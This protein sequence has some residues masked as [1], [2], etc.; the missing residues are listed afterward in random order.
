MHIMFPLD[1]HAVKEYGIAKWQRDF[2]WPVSDNEFISMTNAIEAVIAKHINED[3]PELSD[4]LLIKRNLVSEYGH[5]LHAFWV[6]QRIP[7][8]GL[9]PLYTEKTLWYPQLAEGRLESHRGSLSHKR[10]STFPEIVVANQ[11]RGFVGKAGQTLRI[12]VRPGKLLDYLH[13]GTRGKVYGMPDHLVRCYLQ[14][15]VGWYSLTSAREWTVPLCDLSASYILKLQEYARH[16][17]DEISA[18]AR[19][20][21]IA[22]TSS[23]IAY[24]ISFT[25]DQILD[26]ARALFSLHQFFSPHP[27]NHVVVPVLGAPLQRAVALTVRSLDGRVTS[28]AH[29]GSIGLFDVPTLSVSEFALADEFVTYT[30]GSVEFFERIQIHHPPLRGNH[31]RILSANTSF[32]FDLWKQWSHAPVS[33][34]IK[35]IMIVAFPHA[36]WRKSHGTGMLSLMQLDFELRLVEVLK[37]AGYDVLYKAHPDRLQEIQGIFDTQATVITEDFQYTNARADAFIFGSLRTTA[38]PMALCTNKPI[39]TLYMDHEYP[40]PFEDA[41]A[42]LKKRCTMVR[43]WFD[44]RNRIMFDSEALLAALASPLSSPSKEFVER[45][46]FPQ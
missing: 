41:L 14:E 29:G 23:L 10:D 46:L 4:V 34:A 45:Y 8:K 31:V 32:Y 27:P 42:L 38:F 11:L 21:S 2:F 22:L 25:E 30:K 15:Q 6:L 37:K 28:F 44:E 26:G 40:K 1:I 24:L 19:T 20:Y 16:I 5:I 43:G 35:K 36:P 7:L 33:K 17:V 18:V 3:A 9:A 13:H 39:I 12:N